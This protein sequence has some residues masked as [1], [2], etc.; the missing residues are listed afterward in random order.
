MRT[1][2]D[3]TRSEPVLLISLLKKPLLLAERN[4]PRVRLLLLLDLL[5]S[6]WVAFWL[7]ETWHLSMSISLAVAFLIAVPAIFLTIFLWVLQDLS[8]IPLRIERAKEDLKELLVQSKALLTEKNDKLKGR[9]FFS[10]LNIVYLVRMI[11]ALKNAP[12]LAT[13]IPEI[14]GK[15][16]IMANPIF[17]ISVF[18]SAFV[19]MG[20]TFLSAITLLFYLIR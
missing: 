1:N 8:K 16:V 10:F 15:A 13:L 4:V 6:I 3:I 18:L 2:T 11:S 14:L 20:F 5:N 9:R 12:G 19:T 17:M 7:M